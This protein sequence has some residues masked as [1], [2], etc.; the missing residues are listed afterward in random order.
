MRVQGLPV[1]SHLGH[2]L[3]QKAQPLHVPNM[4]DEMSIHP[5]IDYSYDLSLEKCAQR[6]EDKYDN[7]KLKSR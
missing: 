7:K 6:R 4:F 3:Q 1:R 5:F 2:L